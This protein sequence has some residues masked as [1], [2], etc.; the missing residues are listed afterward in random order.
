[1]MT[2]EQKLIIKI[3]ILVLAIVC[4]ISLIIR[5]S[6]NQKGEFVIP[7]KETNAMDGKPSD[8]PKDCVYQEAKVNN[9]YIVYL[10]AA[11]LFVD[12]KLDIYFTSSANNKGLMRIKVLDLQN[13][14][15]GESGLINPNSYIKYVLLNKNLESNER[16]T[17]KIMHYEKETYYSL[18]EIKIDLHVR[19]K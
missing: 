1:M 5:V 15:I 3:S 12:N 4:I 14:V 19:T 7:E 10:C 13:N 17:I 8:M 9:D 18:G 11:P 2:K 6:T 16:I